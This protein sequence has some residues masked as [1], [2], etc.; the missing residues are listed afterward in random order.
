MLDDLP[1]VEDPTV[2]IGGYV[3][4]FHEIGKSVAGLP[5]WDAP[6]CRP[7]CVLHPVRILTVN[8]L[9][10]LDSDLELLLPAILVLNPPRSSLLCPL[11]L[12]CSFPL[13]S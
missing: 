6:S 1:E 5:D 4:S 12:L 7:R 3:A 11:C 8:P 2:H 10:L 13:T 9:G